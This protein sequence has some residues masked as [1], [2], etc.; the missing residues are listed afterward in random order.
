M[1][2]P[3]A[4]RMILL[5][6]VW[7]CRASAESSLTPRFLQLKPPSFQCPSRPR[8]IVPG[9]AAMCSAPAPFCCSRHLATPSLCAVLPSAWHPPPFQGP[10]SAA[11][12]LE[13]LGLHHLLRGRSMQ[14]T[15]A[16]PRYRPLT[17]SCYLPFRPSSLPETVYNIFLLINLTEILCHLH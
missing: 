14:V 11:F 10:T 8:V 12:P 17:L 3:S 7:W 1:I 13:T 15:A 4:C 16:F 6:W 9:T 2:L 5:L